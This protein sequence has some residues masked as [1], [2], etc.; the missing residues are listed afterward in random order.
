MRAVAG[1]HGTDRSDCNQ[2][3]GR[4]QSRRAGLR[5]ASPTDRKGFHKRIW[6]ENR[7]VKPPRSGPARLHFPEIPGHTAPG[8]RRP[9]HGR[10]GET[11]R[12][13]CGDAPRRTDGTV[14]PTRVPPTAPEALPTP[15]AELERRAHTRRPLRTGVVCLFDDGMKQH[16]IRGLTH[17][18]SA[19]G[20]GFETESTIPACGDRV[21]LRLEVPAGG[22]VWPYAS[23]L[24]ARA[25]IVRIERG[26]AGAR[27]RIAARF[28]DALRWSG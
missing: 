22:G 10:S 9:A 8:A 18:V 6:A 26:A 23:D 25:E 12:I 13:H 20:I 11:A 1:L 5:R 3:G 15:P 21:R 28:L 7:Q 16:T 24:S 14:V 19:G 2:R 27:P 4:L 17:D